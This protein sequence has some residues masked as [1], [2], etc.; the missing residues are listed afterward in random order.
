M[1]LVNEADGCSPEIQSVVKLDWFGHRSVE[2]A[3]AE[4]IAEPLS[5]TLE[6]VC[7]GIERHRVPDRLLDR[8]KLIDPVAV[9]GMVVGDDHAIQS[10]D[11]GLKQLLAD[12]RAA[13]DEKPLSVAFNQD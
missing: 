10:G 11:V 2:A 12:V 7:T 3:V 4:D 1:R 6:H 5:Q 8:A 13:I 9:I